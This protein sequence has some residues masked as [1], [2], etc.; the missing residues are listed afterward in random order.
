MACAAV[1]EALSAPA[2]SAGGECTAPVFGERDRPNFQRGDRRLEP[3]R[4]PGG[5]AAHHCLEGSEG[6]SSRAGGGS[7]GTDRDDAR[8]TVEPLIACLKHPD[9]DQAVAGGQDM[10][11]GDESDDQKKARAEDDTQASAKSV[12][13]IGEIGPAGGGAAPDLPRRARSFRTL[14]GGDRPGPNLTMLARWH[15]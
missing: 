3:D 14:P 11:N 8:A 15:R 7:L 6:P 13:G 1:I 10:S 5:G 2:L 4:R 9:A 12:R